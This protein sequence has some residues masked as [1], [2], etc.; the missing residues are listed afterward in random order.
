M[1]AGV[2]MAN[3]VPVTYNA[4]A[5]PVAGGRFVVS[6]FWRNLA[7]GW[8]N[9]TPSGT[10]PPFGILAFSASAWDVDGGKLY[11]NGGGHADYGGNEVW[12]WDYEN[13]ATNFVRHYPPDFTDIYTG[14]YTPEEKYALLLS[15]IDNTNWPGAVVEAGKPVRPISRHTYASLVWMPH[16]KKFTLGGGSL[17]SGMTPIDYWAHVWDVDQRDFWF[18]DPA[19]KQFDYK[20]SGFKDSTYLQANW[21]RRFVLHEGR[22]KLYLTNINSSNRVHIVEY[23]TLTNVWTAHNSLSPQTSNSIAR[24]VVD[25]KRDRLIVLQVSL[26]QPVRTYSYD[27]DAQSWTELPTTGVA[28]SGLKSE[29]WAVYSTRTDSIY[30]LRTKL[31]GMAKLNLQTLTWTVE[32]ITGPEFGSISG[33]WYYDRRR[34][35]GLIAYQKLGSGIHVWAYKD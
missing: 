16:L 23:N 9:L 32:A 30:L 6:E 14:P 7:P 27:I 13:R 8:T 26:E 12:E 19:V 34:G 10:R 24:V 18:Y 5:S 15:H 28:P 29:A 2:V 31:E 20:G 17:Y 35:C 1:G 33:N 11:I 4:A 25:R 21:Q 22:K 3:P